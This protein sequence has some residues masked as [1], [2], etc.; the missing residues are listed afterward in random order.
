MA[1]LLAAFFDLSRIASLGAIFYLLMDITIH[2]GVF[3]YLRHDV[4]A[5]GSILLLAIAADIFALGAFVY[6]KSI[7]DP[8]ILVIAL[9]GLILIFGFEAL[10]LRRKRPDDTSAMSHDHMDMG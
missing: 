6:I 4:G 1:G 9:I 2:W 8:L 5:R 10:Y 7:Y 3:R